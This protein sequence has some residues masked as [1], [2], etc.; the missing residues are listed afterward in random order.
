[1]SN[2]FLV[3]DKTVAYKHFIFRPKIKWGWLI[4]K[5]S[6]LGV[7]LIGVELGLGV[8]CGSKI[9]VPSLSLLLAIYCG[10]RWGADIGAITGFILGLIIGAL[11]YELLGASALLGTIVGFSAGYFYG[12]LY[13]G[14]YF[15]LM[16]I[17][18]ALSFFADLLTGGITFLLFGTFSSHK[19]IWV[20]ENMACSLPLFFVFEQVLRPRARTPYL[21]HLK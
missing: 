20:A 4:T 15:A 13:V 18:G 14:Q 8:I 10:V 5:L 19:L 17:V 12:K 21:M 1:M 3:L 11:R 7:V 9:P 6:V 16:L 2:I